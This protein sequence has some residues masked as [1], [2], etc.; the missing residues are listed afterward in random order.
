MLLTVKVLRSTQ[1]VDTG[2]SSLK[3]DICAGVTDL[4]DLAHASDKEGV[5]FKKQQRPDLFNGEST[6]VYEPIFAADDPYTVVG[7]VSTLLSW[8]SILGAH[9]IPEYSGSIDI[10]IKTSSG[11]YL[12][13]NIDEGRGSFKGAADLH[14]PAYDEYRVSRDLFEH[15]T[16]DSTHYSVHVYPNERFVRRYY[17][18]VPLM[19]AVGALLIQLLTASIF[20]LFDWAM[21][22]EVSAQQ[23]VL[24]TKRR[25]VR[26]I[27]H[28]VRTPL[29]T[30]R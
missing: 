27:S 29:N 8:R 14:D 15:T 19:A 21:E 26:F 17:T 25:F 30:G 28:E 4:I 6:G 9:L 3:K 13:F 16:S 10:V 20:F 22:D 2:E 5:D 11:Q 1:E 18:S 7:F 24:D 12:T 23:A